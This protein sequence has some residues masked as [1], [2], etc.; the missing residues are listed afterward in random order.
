MH[1]IA[2]YIAYELLISNEAC[3]GVVTYTV[4]WSLFIK[5]I[6][7]D[8]H[9]K[10]YCPPSSQRSK[11]FANYYF[12]LVKYNL[13][14]ASWGCPILHMWLGAFVAYTLLMCLKMTLYQ[15]HTV[16][17]TLLGPQDQDPSRLGVPG[18]LPQVVP[19]YFGQRIMMGL[20]ES[21]AV[22]SRGSHGSGQLHIIERGPGHQ[23]SQKVIS[24]KLILKL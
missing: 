2:Y 8:V 6:I 24:S 23:M 3:I 5:K 17:T 7:I 15:T 19:P 9:Q 4:I 14:F 21:V 20:T 13:R 11:L 16:S 1:L 22:H 12:R 18:R 10:D